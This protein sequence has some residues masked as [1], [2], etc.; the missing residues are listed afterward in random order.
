MDIL[1]FCNLFCADINECRMEIDSCSENCHDTVGS[2]TCS[3]NAGYTLNSN[4]FTCDGM[5]TFECV[6]KFVSSCTLTLQ[7]SMNAVRTP[8]ILVNM[9]AS[10]P[11]DHTLA[12]ATMDMCLTQMDKVV[13]VSILPH[14]TMMFLL[15][16]SRVSGIIAIPV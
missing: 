13:E 8:P 11:L 16:M 4:G 1:W 12:V 2:Y 14:C 6:E 15:C 7:I 5:V 3:C 10:T 9:P